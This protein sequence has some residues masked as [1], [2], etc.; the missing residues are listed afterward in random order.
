LATQRAVAGISCIR[1]RAPAE[2]FALTMKRLSWRTR[3]STQASSRPALRACAL[4][5]SLN[6]ARKRTL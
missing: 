1:P 5:T 2:D 6:G 3:P 4:K